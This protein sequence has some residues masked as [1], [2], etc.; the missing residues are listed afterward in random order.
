MFEVIIPWLPTFFAMAMAG[1]AALYVI[2]DGADLGIG[3][4]SPFVDDADKDTAIS[5]IGPFWD[6]NETWL[7][8]AIGLLL[9]VFPE[10][11]GVVLQAL[12]TPAALMLLGLALRGTAFEF[13]KKVTPAQ[14]PR[15]NAAFA[16]GSLLTALTQGYM[17]AA[18]IVGFRQTPLFD[19]FACV[20]AVALAAAYTLPGACMLIAKTEGALQRQAVIWARTALR[21]AGLSLAAV[22][23]VTPLVSER[24]FERWFHNSTH[25]LLAPIPLLSAWLL[26]RLDRLLKRMP[27]PDD[28][29]AATP[30]RYTAALFLTGFIGLAYSF[31]PYIIPDQLTIDQAAAAPEALVPLFIGAVIVLPCIAGYTFFVYRIFSGKSR[32]EDASY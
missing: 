17:L 9:T 12:Y 8:L 10:A 30:F 7:V 27:L 15:W 19:T 1:S 13:R 6:A 26:W 31:Y 20:S 25:L 18:Y 11:H 21:A 24:I 16:L 28:A 3:M 4:L 22:S 23:L 5:V 14:R 2:L 32:P 29:H